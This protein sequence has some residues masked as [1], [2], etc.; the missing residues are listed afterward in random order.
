M[1]TTETEDPME[2]IERAREFAGKLAEIYGEDLVSV[3]L[4]GS[5]A[6]GDYRE[7]IS[8]LNLLVLLRA[9]NPTVL[10]RG[11]EIA[12]AWSAQGN[13]P[14]LMF[15]EA[16]WRGSADVFPIEYSDMR[17]AHVVLHGPDPFD[18]LHIDWE[19][20]RLNC[21]HEL[22]SKLIQLRE[23]YLLLA[24]DPE[25]LGQMLTR[26]F[27]TFLTLFR[28]AL[29]LAGA[30][31]PS[32]P[33]ATIA[34]IAGHAGFDPSAFREVFNARTRGAELS[35]SADDPVVTGYLTSVS[36][37]TAWLD[38]LQAPSTSA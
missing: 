12:R 5:A 35:P 20:L 6:R 37:A 4:Y 25:G 27:P 9:V 10:H 13:P 16:E 28:A 15:S 31:A 17:D 33:D 3:V 34:A 22:K 26:S 32:D 30:T 36:R 24:D 23:Q 19:H 1:I 21:E 38:G 29:R 7:G 8:D 18:G 2:P 11:T 14:P